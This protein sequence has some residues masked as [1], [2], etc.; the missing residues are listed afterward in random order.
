[1]RMERPARPLN[2]PGVGEG[3]K[4]EFATTL[5]SCQHGNRHVLQMSKKGFVRECCLARGC[6]EGLHLRTKGFQ[7]IASSP[8]TDSSFQPAI[9]GGH[10][11]QVKSSTTLSTASAKD[12]Y[13]ALGWRRFL[14]NLQVAST[15]KTRR[16]APSVP[17]HSEMQCFHCPHRASPFHHCCDAHILRLFALDRQRALMK[18]GSNH[19]WSSGPAGM[20][21]GP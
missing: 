17:R 19:C 21:E 9:A 5:S 13:P 3:D 20:I 2:F 18:D 6:K 12:L 15:C 14:Q 10:T 11:K 7:P 8:T 4:K 16:R 1:M